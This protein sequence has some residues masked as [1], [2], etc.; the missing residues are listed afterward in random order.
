MSGWAA[1]LLFVRFNFTL[2]LLFLAAAMAGIS[3]HPAI[4]GCFGWSLLSTGGIVALW[5]IHSLFTTVRA[6]WT[7]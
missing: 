6:F 4:P 5:A 7:R 2:N 3:L 1:P